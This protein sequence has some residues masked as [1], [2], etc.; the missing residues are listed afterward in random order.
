[1]FS[2]LYRKALLKRHGSLHNVVWDNYE[3]NAQKTTIIGIF[4][5]FVFLCIFVYNEYDVLVD[6]EITLQNLV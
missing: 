4:S 5:V 3:N 2:Y 1:M 6:S